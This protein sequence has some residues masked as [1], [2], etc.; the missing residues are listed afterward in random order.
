[1]WTTMPALFCVEYLNFFYYCSRVHCDIY[2][3]S[4]SIS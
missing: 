1:M 2:K 3:S 4:F